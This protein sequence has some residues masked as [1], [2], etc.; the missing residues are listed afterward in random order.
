ML[1]PWGVCVI[2]LAALG[3]AEHWWIAA[4]LALAYAQLLIAPDTVRLYQYAF[5][6][7]VYATMLVLAME[8]AMLAVVLHWFNPWQRHFI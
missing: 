8:W 1:G 2:G 7:L 6:A 4:M 3:G 5:P